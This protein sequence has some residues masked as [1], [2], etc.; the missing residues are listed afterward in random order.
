ML[1]HTHNI[2]I[3]LYILYLLYYIILYIILYLIILHT[4]NILRMGYDLS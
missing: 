4:Y 2:L 1:L 3:I